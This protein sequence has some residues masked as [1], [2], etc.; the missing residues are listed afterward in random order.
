MKK[1]PYKL[2]VSYTKGLIDVNELTDKEKQDLN[3][4]IFALNLLVP[5]DR[6]IKECTNFYE[7]ID[8]VQYN[9]PY[10]DYLA[11]KFQVEPIL[12][13]CQIESILYGDM[14]EKQKEENKKKILKRENNVLYV[15]FNKKNS[16]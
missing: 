6:L 2:L 11:C 5:K 3:A 4:D 7:D 8:D 12:I 16:K 1:N 9:D 14:R 15:D 13:R 10:V